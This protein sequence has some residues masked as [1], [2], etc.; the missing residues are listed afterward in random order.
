MVTVQEIF[1]MAIHLM[2]EQRET[3]G[4]TVTVDTSE[5][6]YR[7]ISILNTVIPRVFKYSTYYDR[8]GGQNVPILV[9]YD[10]KNPDFDQPVGLDDMLALALLP[11]YLAAELLSA[12]NDV[13]SA[14]FMNQYQEALQD[15]RSNAAGEF[16]AIST[17]YGLF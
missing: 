14:W 16:E 12:E 13:L 8:D 15:V 10:Y 17:P 3:D 11:P 1:D 9:N 4:S 6:K 5:Y 2:D 7:T